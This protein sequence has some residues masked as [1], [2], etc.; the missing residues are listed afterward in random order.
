MQKISLFVILTVI[1]TM[2]MA[3]GQEETLGAQKISLTSDNTAYQEGD[4]I[5]IT[6]Q[7]EKVIPGMPVTLQVFFEKN[8]LQVS[9]VKVSQDGKFTDTFTAAGPQ[10]QNEGTVTINAG[11]GGQDTEL[12]IEFFKNTTGEFTSNYEVKIPAGGTFDVQYTMKGGIISSMD[13]NQKNLSLEINISTSSDGNLNINLPRDSID[14]INNNGQDIDF[15]VLMYEGNTE[16]PI[17]TDFKNADTEDQFRSINIPVKNG[18]TKIEIIGT[19]VVPEFGTIAMIVLAVAIVSII[20]VSAKSR[21][22]IM[23]RI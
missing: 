22:S 17:Q 15:I 3:F 2:P 4:V 14:S 7:I 5:T 21:L 11:Y 1:L 19:H 6:G 13:L 18:D 20:A 10:W 16:I 23:P 9:Q 8:L 12:N